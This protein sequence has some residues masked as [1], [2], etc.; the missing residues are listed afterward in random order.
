ML[1]DP[2][3]FMGR[4]IGN[5]AEVA[6]RSGTLLSGHIVSSRRTIGVPPHGPKQF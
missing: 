3:L 2:P 4:K 1:D 6:Y 5:H